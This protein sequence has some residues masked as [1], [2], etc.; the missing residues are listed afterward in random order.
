MIDTRIGWVVIS[1]SPYRH[2]YFQAKPLNLGLTIFTFSLLAVFKIR[3][4]V[5]GIIRDPF[6]SAF[7][8]FVLAHATE[9]K[10]GCNKILYNTT[11]HGMFFVLQHLIH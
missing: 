6:T 3:T 9:K 2:P 7:F 5:P 10:L 1:H 4:H 11:S 8:I